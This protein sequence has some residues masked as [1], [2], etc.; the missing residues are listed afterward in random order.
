MSTK[1][2]NHVT[3][4]GRVGKDPELRYFE[5]GSSMASFSLAIN[6]PTKNK[7]TDWFDIKLWGKQ[8]EIAGEYVRKGSLIA[9][10]GQADW[11][12]WND[13][14]TGD[15]VTKPVISGNELRLLGS[16]ADNAAFT[17]NSGNN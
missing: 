13:K 10:V 14:T 2:I 9:I 7:E 8:A 3:L 5:S 11:D 16:K 17:A 1:E 4:V 15:L 12:Y 6:R